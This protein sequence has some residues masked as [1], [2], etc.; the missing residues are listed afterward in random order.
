[1]CVLV[2]LSVEPHVS[3]HTLILCALCSSPGAPTIIA[4]FVSGADTAVNVS[5]PASNGGSG[6]KQQSCLHCMLRLFQAHHFADTFPHCELMHACCVLLA[7]LLTTP[8]CAAITSFY[9]VA[10]PVGGGSNLTVNGMG[11][12]L[13]GG[14]RQFS[15][16]AG[17]ALA[18]G[19]Q[20]RVYAYAVNTAGT[21]PPSTAF[22]FTTPSSP[23]PPR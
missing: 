17:S 3:V 6:S 10:V 13:P 15:F 7:T 14:Q 8:C 12:S 18:P 2:L 21:S 23:P 16:A 22:P 19:Q 5:A 4:M 20:Y 1:M 9:I 11:L